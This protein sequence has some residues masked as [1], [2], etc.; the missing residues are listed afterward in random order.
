MELI[1]GTHGLPI[2]SLG[3][4]DDDVQQIVIRGLA[5][6]LMFAGAADDQDSFADG[7]LCRFGYRQI[8]NRYQ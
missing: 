3:I 1:D 7:L 2:V 5:D 6:L 4:A 8:N